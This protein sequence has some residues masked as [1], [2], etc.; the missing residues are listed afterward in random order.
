PRNDAEKSFPPCAVIAN[1][2]RRLLYPAPSLRAKR[3]N[4]APSDEATATRSLSLPLTGRDA[5]QRQGGVEA[6]QKRTCLSSRRA[7]RPTAR[8]ASVG[9][10]P[11]EPARAQEVPRHAAEHPFA[12]T[13]VAI[14][15][16]DDHVR[17]EIR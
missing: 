17:P 1:A 6:G 14:G 10:Q 8:R 9:E 12:Q 4:P 5:A 13:A 3:S 16:R 15:A 11:V 2:D 7:T